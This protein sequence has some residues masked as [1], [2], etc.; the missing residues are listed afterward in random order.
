M[1]WNVLAVLAACALSVG[2]ATSVTP[3][4]PDTYMVSASGAGFSSGAERARA[5]R[6]ANEWC[7]KRGLVMV[8]VSMDSRDG[9]Y[10]RKAPSA[11]LVFRALPPGDPEIRRPNVEGPNHIQRVQVR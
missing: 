1:K 7:A 6:I 10:G 4:G 5:Y 3:A 9:E 11:D 8:P 2:C